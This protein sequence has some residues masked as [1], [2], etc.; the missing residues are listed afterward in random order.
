MFT[1]ELMVLSVSLLVVTLAVAITA[2]VARW[3]FR[4]NEI[5]TCL[6]TVVHRL[7]KLVELTQ[8]QGQG[9]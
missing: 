5:L 6:V 3:L 7:D 1:P 4:I 2:A 9:K 8:R